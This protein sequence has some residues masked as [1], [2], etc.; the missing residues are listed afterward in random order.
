MNWITLAL[1]LLNLALLLWLALKPAR[2]DDE[3]LAKLG[4]DLGAEW[5]QRSEQLSREVRDEVARSAVGTRQ[6]LAA[7]LALFQQTTLAHHGDTTRTQN[8]Q[9][10]SFR[11]QLAG[12]QQ[13][14]A[15]SQRDSMQQQSQQGLA[16][17][18]AQSLSLARF[19]EAQEAALRR[20][21]E[22]V[23]EQLRVLS[24][25]NERRLGEVR[26]T[27]E[28]RLQALQADNEKKLE[29]M[30]QTVDEKLHAT[31]EA[32]L[33]ESF[34]QVAERLEQVHRGLG[35][36]Q[37]LASDVGSLNR[38]LNNVKTRGI[39]GEVQL[40]GLLEQVFTPD[41][42]AVN[43]ETV[44]GS[45][46]RVEFAIRLPG[47]G[48]ADGAPVWLPIDAKFPREDYERLLE[49]QDK[50]DVAGVEAAAKALEVR[51]RQE[52]KTIRDKYLAPPHTADFAILFVPTEGLY[53]EALRRPG[54]VEALLRECRV[55]LA[56]PTTLLA[57]LNSLQMG[58]RTL[59]LE[60]RSSEVWQVLGAVKTEFGKF[61]D[62]LAKT[63]KKL[64]E[65]S[66][67]ISSV[68]T[69]TRVMGRALKQVEA[70][71][72]AQTQALLP[73]EPDL[74]DDSPQG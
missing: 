12:F 48:G 73:G 47:Q 16:L 3:A 38:V 24:D 2:S 54:L 23:A 39:F 10:D 13:S 33:G 52:A 15:D 60:K 4:A 70:M 40:A 37:R 49:A 50:A 11:V 30:R 58:F 74:T 42:Y 32:R 26:L 45:G 22:G 66:N 20:L 18:E 34:K 14:L 65:A 61:G 67:T 69:R 43:V 28:T 27:V 41:Q 29:Q 57:T 31:L 51:L 59:A 7:S 53:A 62:V 19:T 68:E 6:E 56:G 63:R 21:G 71:P 1:L 25:A 8:E 44:P 46:A 5:R 35:D 36:M 17:R 9:L 64:D 72:D 55:M